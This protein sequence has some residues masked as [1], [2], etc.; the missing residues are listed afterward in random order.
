MLCYLYAGYTMLWLGL[1]RSSWWIIFSGLFWGIALHS[2]IQVPPFWAVSMVLPLGLVIWRKQWRK[3]AMIG[4]GIFIALITYLTILR[5][6]SYFILPS[7]IEK[8]L[9]ELLFNSVVLVRDW[10]VRS[11]AFKIA[12]LFALPIL[13]GYPYVGWQLLVRLEIFNKFIANKP[14]QIYQKENGDENEGDSRDVIE[15]AL[16]GLGAS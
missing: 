9:V 1:T 5:V 11:L 15:L 12:I 6:Q 7:P 10:P 2:K 4:F 8:P 13:I 3:G 14:S 16:W